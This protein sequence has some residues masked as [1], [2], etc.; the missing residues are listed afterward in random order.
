MACGV[1]VIAVRNIYVTKVYRHS[2]LTCRH[3]VTNLQSVLGKT[4]PRP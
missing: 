3:N 2:S 1:V 4:C